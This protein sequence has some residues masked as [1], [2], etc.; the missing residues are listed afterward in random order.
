MHEI[1]NIHTELAHGIPSAAGDYARAKVGALARYAPADVPVATARLDF[2]GPHLVVAH[3]RLDVN[4]VPV[5]AKAAAATYTEAV[6]LLQDKL[7]HQ[8]LAMSD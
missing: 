3:G 5:N 8:L 1:A 4:G 7:K 2:D 6:D